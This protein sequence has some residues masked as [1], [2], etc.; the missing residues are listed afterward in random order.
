MK[1]FFFLFA[2]IVSSCRVLSQDHAGGSVSVDPIGYNIAFAEAY[3]P[4]TGKPLTEVNKQ[5]A[6]SSLLNDNWGDGKVLLRNGFT[7]K[8]LELQFDLF[9]NELHFRKNNIVYL[10]VDS[11]KEFSM[12]FKDSLELYSV[13]FRSGYPGIQKKTDAAFYKVVADG[14][15]VQLLN[16]ESKEVRESYEYL[17]PM[18]KEYQQKDEYFVYDVKA[19]ELKSINLKKSSLLKNMPAFADSINAFAGKTNYKLKSEKELTELF[20]FLNQ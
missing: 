2:V 8:N 15:K 10:F 11:I 7:L 18:R 16:Y 20:N 3:D 9:K 14:S 1:K 6:G 19:G 4:K 5:V 13:V 17:G 12:Q